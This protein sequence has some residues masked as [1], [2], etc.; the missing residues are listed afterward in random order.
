MKA[1]K[2]HSSDARPAPEAAIPQSSP[3]DLTALLASLE[4]QERAIAHRRAEAEKAFYD[5]GIARAKVIIRARPVE[6]ERHA[7]RTPFSTATIL[8]SLTNCSNV[9]S[10]PPVTCL[11]LNSVAISCIVSVTISAMS[12]A[13]GARLGPYEILGPLGA[14]GMGEVYRARDTRLDRIVAVKV[15]PEQVSQNP[16]ARE[17]FEREARAVSSLNHPHI[18]MLYD[19]GRRGDADYLV[20]EYLEG[21]TFARLFKKGPLPFQQVLLWAI[22]IAGALD[23]AHRHHITHRDLKPGNIMLTKA[24]VKV[25]DFGLAKVHHAE[26]V[27]ESEQSTNTLTEEG[28]VLGTLQ[29]MAPEQLEGKA[30]D[31]RTDIFAF[32]AVVYEMVTGK[33]AFEGKSRASVIGAILHIEPPAMSSLQAVTPPALDRTIR[34]CLAKD[35]DKR[36]QS[37]GDVRDELEWIREAGSQVGVTTAQPLIKW[38]MLSVCGALAVAAVCAGIAAGW[39]GKSVSRP[40]VSRF[41]ITLP[42]T[43]RLVAPD[44]PAVAIS[45]DGKD[46]VYV[47]AQGGTQ[48]LFLRPLATLDT[49]PIAETEGAVAPFFSPDGQW[50][51]FFADGKLKKVALNGGG[52]VTLAQAPHPAGGSWSSEGAVALQPMSA[53]V[54]GLQQVAQDGGVLQAL[55]RVGKGQN[56]HCWPE[57]LPDGKAILFAGSP[58]FTAWGNAQIGIQQGGRER[59]NLAFGSQPRYARAGYL[60]YARSGTLMAMQF[61]PRR[62][63]PTGAAVP[64]IEG[65]MQSTASGAAQYDVSSTGTLVYLSGGGG[66][67]LSRLVWVNRGGTEQL[68]PTAS[69]RYQFPRVSPDGGRLVFGI[70]EQEMQIWVYTLARNTLTRVTLEGDVNGTPIWSPD[71]KRIAFDSNRLGPD[72]LFWQASDGSSVGAE[73]LSASDH[74]HA[75]SSFSP[76]GKLLAYVEVSPQT[77]RDIWILRLSDHKA[78]P[79]LR[80]IYEETAPRFSPDGRFLAYSSDETGRREIYIQSYPGPSGKWQISDEGGQEPVWNPNG[81]ELFYRNG[82][83]MIAVEIDSKSG[84]SASKPRILFEGPYLRTSGSFPYYDVSANGQEFL[85][86]KPLDSQTSTAM[87]LNVVLNWWEELKAKVPK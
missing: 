46:V 17:R 80:T 63:V 77:G 14:G 31:A 49:K 6:P 47:A 12:L 33:K 16:Q 86:L 71:G 30:A 82:S 61:D 4:E 66:D 40:S 58:T 13:A 45:P 28:V 64:V 83:K 70:A 75:P 69:R 67:S 60:L 37:A 53:A 24:G 72:N 5:D 39:Y 9:R 26:A 10:L 43:Q 18:C 41:T 1:S 87:Q 54:Q 23:H 52:A 62:L 35:A 32:G 81:R 76:D 51:G 79:F 20:M 55:T 84:F 27:P 2:Q 48:Q 15:L 85:M 29:Y 56:V 57:F 22:E 21:E 25:L 68:L 8:S 44:Q 3:D 7:I 50:V 65:V 42:P 36:W 78:E 74:T 38:R 59:N 73:R 19:V 11:N 34:K